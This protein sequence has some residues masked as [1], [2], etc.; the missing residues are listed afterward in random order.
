MLFGP[1]GPTLTNDLKDWAN[2]ELVCIVLDVSSIRPSSKQVVPRGEVPIHADRPL[3]VGGICK[4][5]GI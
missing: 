2:I 5:Y 4:E 3:L 1:L